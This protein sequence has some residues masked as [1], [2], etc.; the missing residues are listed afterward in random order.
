VQRGAELQA[1]APPRAPVAGGEEE[2]EASGE[3][4]G[5]ARAAAPCGGEGTGEARAAVP[6]E[7]EAC[8]GRGEGSRSR[9]PQPATQKARHASQPATQ[10]SPLRPPQ[11][12]EKLSILAGACL[13][14]RLP[15]C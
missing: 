2:E 10:A 9:R 13:T 5:E 11:Q 15:S 7:E 3:G 14:T 12:L 4:T 6:C 1:R 8:G